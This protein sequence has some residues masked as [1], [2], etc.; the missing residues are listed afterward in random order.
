[1][2]ADFKRHID[3]DWVIVFEWG[4]VIA[5]YAILLSDER[6][7]LLDNIAVAPGHQHSGIGHTLIERVEQQADV[8]GHRSLE[9]YTNVIMTENIRWYEK[10]GFIEDR[11]V[12][13]DGFHRV[14]M[15]KA[16]GPRP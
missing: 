7:P 11:R 15:K 13:E 1:M 9:L 5:G 16:L 8:L 6:R 12:V 2:I 10:I 3:E 4:G 14:Y